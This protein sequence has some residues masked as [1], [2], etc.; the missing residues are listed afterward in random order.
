M[1]RLNSVTFGM[2]ET[3]ETPQAQEDS[4]TQAKEESALSSDSES[5]MEYFHAYISALV[6]DCAALGTNIL[7]SYNWEEAQA[8]LLSSIAIDDGGLDSMLGVLEREIE[9]TPPTI[10]TIHSVQ[11]EGIELVRSFDNLRSEAINTVRSW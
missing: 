5:F 3:P 10:E 9:R 7:P 2:S 1:K 11:A 6:N 4:L 8:S